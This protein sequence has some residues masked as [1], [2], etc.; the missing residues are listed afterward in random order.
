M[1]HILNEIKI[2]LITPMRL[3][4]EDDISVTPRLNIP[5]QIIKV[6]GK[7]YSQLFIIQVLPEEYG[8]LCSVVELFISCME[9]ILNLTSFNRQQ[10][11]VVNTWRIKV[12]S[13]L[14]KSQ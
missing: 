12:N 5:A 9:V 8:E 13:C 2:L 3:V 6:L 1:K 11:I 10:K 4:N 7:V 14:S